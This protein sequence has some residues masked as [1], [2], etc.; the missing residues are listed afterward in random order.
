MLLAARQA[1]ERVFFT[2]ASIAYPEERSDEGYLT[3]S[4]HRQDPSLRSG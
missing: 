1:T 3:E 4:R 2:F